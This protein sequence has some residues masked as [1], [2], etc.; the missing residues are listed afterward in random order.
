MFSAATWLATA[1]TMLHGSR[2]PLRSYHLRRCTALRRFRTA[3]FDLRLWSRSHHLTLRF[4]HL[5]WWLRFR[6]AYTLTLYTF[7]LLL[8]AR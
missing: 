8:L 4:L 2:R 1:A 3:L 6:I 7:S 5:N